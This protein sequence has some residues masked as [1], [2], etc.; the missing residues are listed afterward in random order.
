[1]Y[2]LSGALTLY[3]GMCLNFYPESFSAS[4]G[5]K[6]C[7]LFWMLLY[8][9]LCFTHLSFSVKYGNISVITL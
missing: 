5:M 4:G 3:H 2:S 8:M 1:M 9:L 6:N 7:W